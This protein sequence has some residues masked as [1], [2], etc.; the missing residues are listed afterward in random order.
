MIILM[1]VI[2]GFVIIPGHE[3]QFFNVPVWNQSDNLTAQIN[4]IGNIERG[5]S[6]LIGIADSNVYRCRCPKSGRDSVRLDESGG[7]RESHK[8]DRLWT[9]A[10]TQEAYVSSPM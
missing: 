3:K 6:V 1:F 5:I 4:D 10:V 7:E 8:Y 9:N 2:I